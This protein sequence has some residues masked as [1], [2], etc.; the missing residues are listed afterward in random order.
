[1]SKKDEEFNIF[2]DYL[3][4]AGLKEKPVI[5][6]KKP[7]EI[8]IKSGKVVSPHE[9]IKIRDILVDV[10]EVSKENKDITFFLAVEIIL[11]IVLILMLFGIIPM[12]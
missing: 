4:R 1:M 9:K 6:K 8:K 12:F 11:T 2:D 3:E 5:V 10:K 7:Q